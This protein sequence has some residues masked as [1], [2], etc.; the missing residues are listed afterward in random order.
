MIL[1]DTHVWIWWVQGDA[2]LSNSDLATLDRKAV[3][4]VG[5]CAISCWEVAML[6][7][8][9]RIAFSCLL[10]EWLDC[11][12]AY[13]GVELLPLGRNVAVE[14]CRLPGG[15][16]RDPADRILIAEAR[17]RNCFLVTADEKI[18][19]YP[20]VRAIRPGDLK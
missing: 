4:G 3:E 9:G 11:A 1:L 7:E 15:L 18:L 14:S 17:E 12:L 16:H 20:F 5:I 13:P 19:R 10:D 6:H 2:R 8:C